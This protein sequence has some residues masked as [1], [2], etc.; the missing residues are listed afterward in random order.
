[1]VFGGVE[2]ERLQLDPHTLWSGHHVE[3]DSA[4]ARE[5]I[6]RIRQLLFEGKYAEAN[7]MGRPPGPP[8]NPAR[9][10]ARA[11]YQTLGDLLLDL[12]HSGQ[13]EEYRRELNL[14]TGM[15]RVDYPV[16]G[17]RLTAVKNGGEDPQLIALYFQ[18][19]R[20]LLMSSSRP[21]TMPAN[22]QGM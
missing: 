7:A 17:E 19:G 4:D 8:S 6:Q 10:A 12:H 16:G 15:A 2:H 3:N 20:Y 22:L 14:D 13:P 21:G 1:M 9:L 18:Y 11:S 5:A